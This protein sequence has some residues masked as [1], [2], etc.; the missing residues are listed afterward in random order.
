MAINPHHIVE[1]INGIRCSIIEKK[2]TTERTAFLK[3]ILEFN[4][5]EVVVKSD[6]EGL[7]TLGVTNVVF[8]PI[9]ALYGRVLKNLNGK[10]VT[11]AI[12][13]Q[14]EPTGEFYFDYKAD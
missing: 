5:M 8:N 1:E 2:A 7:F 10:L 14:K 12:W 11:P 4:G 13:Y 3:A 6:G 9:H